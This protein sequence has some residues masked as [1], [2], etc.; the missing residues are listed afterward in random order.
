MNRTGGAGFKL[1]VV[2]GDAPR[3]PGKVRV[4]VWSANQACWS[5]PQA[6]NP[7]GLKPICYADLSSRHRKVVD[8]AMKDI[9]QHQGVVRYGR[10]VFQVG[11]PWCADRRIKPKTV[12]GITKLAPATAHVEIA[13]ISGTVKGTIVEGRMVSGE[14]SMSAASKEQLQKL[15]AT[16]SDWM[17]GGGSRKA[18][19]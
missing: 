7:D 3:S 12:E 2:L 10:G 6:V 11:D 1:V 14:V 5:N 13:E 4:C 8:D 16:L 19:R 17:F 18:K 15:N 9:R